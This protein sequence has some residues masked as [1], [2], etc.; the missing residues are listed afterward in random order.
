MNSNSPIGVF[1]SGVGGLTVLK[2][3]RKILPQEDFIFFG[4]SKRA[5]Y[6]PRSDGEIKEFL[7]EFAKYFKMRDVKMAV[8]ACNTMTSIG[9]DFIKFY[10]EYFL[11]PMNPSITEALKY[12]PNK[13]IG[14]IATKATIEKNMHK[15]AARVLDPSIEVFGKACPSFVP[16]IESGEI[17][18]E[19]MEMTVKKYLAHFENT[20]I[21]SL[22]LGCT[23]YP[24]IENLIAENIEDIKI[25][26]PA[27]ETAKQAKAV[28]ENKNLLHTKPSKGSL[29]IIFSSMTDATTQI[30]ENILGEKD[31]ILREENLR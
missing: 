25:I 7:F 19:K 17:A 1:D 6:G 23:H 2:E 29:E 18:G 20:G 24:I 16:L 28:L 10:D 27:L 31:Y 3:L 30:V 5:P 13:K 14:V 4:D 15:N 8:C 9:Q 11:I 12:S 21:K 26:N 22:I